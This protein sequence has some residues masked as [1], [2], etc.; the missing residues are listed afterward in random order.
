MAWYAVTSALTSFSFY[1]G[2]DKP[3][4]WISWAL[5]YPANLFNNDLD[6][7]RN[8][9]KSQIQKKKVE[10]L[11]LLVSTLN[12]IIRNQ[13]TFFVVIMNNCLKVISAHGAPL[14]GMGGFFR[15][16][17]FSWGYKSF[18]GKR[19]YGEIFLNWRTNDQIMPR[20]GRSCMW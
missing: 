6:N 2:T 8:D 19:N 11:E 13:D 12:K 18:F 14:Y 7:T 20:F 10:F 3:R 16:R 1:Q 4:Y 15:K 5:K 9:M 17:S